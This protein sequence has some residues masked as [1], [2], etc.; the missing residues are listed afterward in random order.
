MGMEDAFSCKSGLL[1]ESALYRVQGDLSSTGAFSPILHTL[2]LPFRP[3]DLAEG[4][5]ICDEGH[6]QKRRQIER[7]AHHVRQPNRL[8]FFVP[9][10]RVA[11]LLRRIQ[12]KGKPVADKKYSKQNHPDSQNQFDHN[13]VMSREPPMGPDR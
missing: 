10:G 6:E 13:P 9:E 5:K 11:R 12:Q 1:A 7:S 8:E 2:L 3:L 4:L